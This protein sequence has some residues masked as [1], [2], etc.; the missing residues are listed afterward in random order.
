MISEA[1]ID[2]LLSNSAALYGRLDEEQSKFNEIKTAAVKYESSGKDHLVPYKDSKG[3]WTIGHGTNLQDLDQN[4]LDI[5]GDEFAGKDTI[6]K[7]TQDLLTN[8]N[9][10]QAIGIANTVFKGLENESKDTQKLFADMAYN[11]GQTRLSK[12][13]D[14]IKAFDDKDWKSVVAGVKDSEYFKRDLPQNKER[15]KYINK[16]LDNVGKTD[17][18]SRI[19]DLFKGIK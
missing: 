2:Q 17:S 9:V 18:S 12:F 5:I 3:I 14:T 6:T 15:Y 4:E 8:Y 1:E 7:E 16:L 13:K 11:M 10:D 19:K